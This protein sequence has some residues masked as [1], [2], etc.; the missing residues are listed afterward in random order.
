[1]KQ[2]DVKDLKK[3]V[4]SFIETTVPKDASEVQIKETR[5][6]FICGMIFGFR[7][8]TD[9]VNMDDKEEA[10]NHLTNYNIQLK[11]MEDKIINGEE[12]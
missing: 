5:K 6:A 9:M 7:L 12:V 10:M 2:E 8:P 4:D 1:M 11:N 3:I